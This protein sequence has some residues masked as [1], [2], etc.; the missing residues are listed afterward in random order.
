MEKQQKKQI[1]LGIE[2]GKEFFAHEM[3]V[4][5]NPT[6]FILDFRCITPRV[7]PRSRETPF[8]SLKHNIVMMEPF[9]AKRML[10]VLS[11]MINEYEKQYSRIE[12]PKALQK[13]EEDIKKLEKK[14]SKE[15]MPSYFG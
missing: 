5:F 6:Q 9:H 11:N 7:D 3:S 15:T 12:K 8:V 14:N 1:N 10:E 13:H 2:D 4:N